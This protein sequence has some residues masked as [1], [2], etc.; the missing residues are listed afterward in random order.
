MVQ[1]GA[2][3]YHAWASQKKRVTLGWVCSGWRWLRSLPRSAEDDTGCWGY[4][5]AVLLF[6]CSQCQLS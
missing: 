4:L 6:D 2:M 5:G 3:G 1:Y